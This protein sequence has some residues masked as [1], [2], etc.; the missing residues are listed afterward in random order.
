MPS[1]PSSTPAW[2]QEPDVTEGTER[3]TGRTAIVTGASG[4]IGA[5]IAAMLGRRGYGLTLTA[6]RQDALDAV[7]A[8]LRGLG[9]PHVLVSPGDLAD[10]A[11]PAAVVAAHTEAFGGLDCLV[12]NAGVGSAGAIGSYPRHRFDKTVAVNLSGPFE[13]LQQCVPLMRATADPAT[14]RGA[15]VVA[16]ASITGRYAEPGL[17]V[18]GAT[19]AALISLVAT[20]N[21]ELSAEGISATALCPGYVETDM[22][23]WVRD[24][25]PAAQ[26]IRTDDIVRLVEAVVDLSPQAVVPEIVISRAGTSGYEA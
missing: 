10:E 24:R 7:A 16:L 21:T 19:K 26:M 3:A 8:D 15:R 5:G 12:L 23:L 20:V 1:A 11:T 14:G 13:L 2:K 9:S 4:G 22:T 6:R 18:Y 17:A 25:V